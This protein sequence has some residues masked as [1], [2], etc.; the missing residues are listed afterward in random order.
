MAPPPHYAELTQLMRCRSADTARSCHG[1]KLAGQVPNLDRNNFKGVLT[2]PSFNRRGHQDGGSL[3]L[4]ERESDGDH[5]KT[6]SA[7]ILVFGLGVLSSTSGFAD[8]GKTTSRAAALQ[9]TQSAVGTSAAAE[10][11]S[12][13]EADRERAVSETAVPVVPEPSTYIAGMLLLLPLMA[14]WRTRS[15]TAPKAS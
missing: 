13:M 3:S 2:F 4:L 9:Q 7:I 10:K 14:A 1:P 5:V 12:V 15:K 6:L 11:E 8:N